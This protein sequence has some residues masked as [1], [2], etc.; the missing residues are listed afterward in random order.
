[1]ALQEI[2]DHVISLHEGFPLLPNP[3]L[4]FLLR[5]AGLPLSGNGRQ[6][7]LQS[8]V[9]SCL[10]WPRIVL[11]MTPGSD[12]NYLIWRGGISYAFGLTKFLF[13]D[14]IRI[15]SYQFE[16]RDSDLGKLASCKK[17]RGRWSLS[18]YFTYL[19]YLA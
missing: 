11:W 3:L 4:R 8:V 19:T 7:G 2:K 6:R 1:M 13:G 15:Y 12:L 5:K 17:R 10:N 18:V 16:T 9:P 14:L